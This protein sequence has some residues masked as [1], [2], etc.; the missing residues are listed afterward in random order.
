MNF[1]VLFAIMLHM[2]TYELTYIISPEITQEEAGALAKE[3]ESFIQS[4]EG[5]VLKQENPIAKTLSHQVKKHASGF[6]GSIEFQ[7]EPEKIIQLEERIKKDG[8]ISRHMVIIK[9]PVKAA[10]ERR[11]RTKPVTD[12]QPETKIE[13]REPV[14]PKTE[15]KQKVELK[16]IEQKLDEILGE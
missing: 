9:E 13:A 11:T 6:V 2:K 14:T 15:P 7:L 10:K 8:K 1:Q 5:S 12:L 3:F 16:D 4:N